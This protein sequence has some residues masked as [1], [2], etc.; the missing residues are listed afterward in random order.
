MNKKSHVVFYLGAAFGLVSLGV[1]QA[2]AQTT[3]RLIANNTPQFA[4]SGKNLGPANTAQTIDVVIWLNPHNPGQLETLAEDLYEPTSSH[5]HDWLKPADIA[6]RFAPTA[7][8]AQTVGEFLSAHNLPV[9]RVGPDNFSVRARGTLGD[10]E[11]AFR[12]QINNFDVNGKTYR[13]NTSD[14]YVEGPAAGLVA[15][16]SGLD[17]LAYEH[18]LVSTWKPP[19]K[20]SG[21]GFNS[22]A[23]PESLFFTTDCFTGVQTL[24]FSGTDPVGNPASAAYKGNTYNGTNNP[25][26]C[27]YTPPEIWTAYNLTGLYKEGFD[28]TGQTIVIIDWCGSPTIQDDANT[29]SAQ[30]GLPALTKS[31]FH[32]YYSGA[33]PTCGG[34]DPEINID[35][36]WA[37]AIAPGANIALVV[38]PSATFMDVDDAEL[39]ALANGLGNVISGSYGSEEFFTPSAVLNEENLLN[40]LAALLGVSANFSSGDYG[41]FT[42]DFPSTF[43]P[44]SVSAPADSPWATAVGGV[45]LALNP[46]N[47]IKWQTGWGNNI[48]DLVVFGTIYDP[49]NDG[50]FYAGSGGGPSAVFS[51]PSFQ[52]KLPGTQ[53]LLPDISWLADPYTGGAIFITEGP[54]T[55]VW[56]VYGGTSLSCPMFS[57]LWAIANQEA[58]VPLGQA[59]R[60][61]YSLPPGLITDVLPVG[62]STNVIGTVRDPSPTFYPANELSAPLEGTS[63]YYSAL[64]DIIFDY[65]TE[66]LVTFGTDSS[67]RTAPGWDDVTGLGT[68]NGKAFADYFK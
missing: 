15:S 56:A 48:N 31:N 25:A 12:V 41:D 23:T 55:L 30:F 6:S 18:P 17:N 57:A 26:G 63:T 16:V 49:L 44:P 24:T 38:P 36:E 60:H 39:Y 53:R 54:G 13:G 14:P 37:H 59:A 64:W 21:G 5:Y 51:K 35:V 27:G 9:V 10:V 1:I 2:A 50:F 8:E 7:A 68:P 32:I 61:L 62:S 3:G 19:Q 11:K 28:G 20:S 46:N 33:T 67:L 52:N 34:V 45:T 65:E 4:T 42:F 22:L 29:F 43:N 66:I 40:Q 58:G 47:T